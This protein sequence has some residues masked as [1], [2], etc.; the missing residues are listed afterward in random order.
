MHSYALSAEDE[1]FNENLSLNY[2]MS[3]NSDPHNQLTISTGQFQLGAYEE[4][5]ES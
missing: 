5:K 2:Q 1:T 4:M 3:V